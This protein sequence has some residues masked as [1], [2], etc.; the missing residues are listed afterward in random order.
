MANRSMSRF[1]HFLSPGLLPFWEGN[2]SG[3]Q[4]E[5]FLA[6]PAGFPALP[7]CSGWGGGA[8][9]ALRPL[10]ASPICRLGALESRNG[11]LELG[12]YITRAAHHH[13]KTSH[14]ASRS[15]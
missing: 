11:R 14:R 12:G 9:R 2:F 8:L 6:T 4:L 7:I 13:G 3:K 5:L 10:P 15:L 1:P